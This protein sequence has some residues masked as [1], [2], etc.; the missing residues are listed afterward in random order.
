[1]NKSFQRT[2]VKSR[3]KLLVLASTYPRWYGDYEPGF[4]HE[5][6]KR[7]TKSFDVVVLCPHAPDAREVEIFDGV[8]I[9][10]YRYAPAGLETLVNSGGIV[11]NLKE[12]PWKW[13]LI[14]SFILMQMLWTWRIIKK[15]Q[16]DVIHAHWLLPQGLV[17]ALLK[18]IYKQT[19]PFVVTSH[20]A[21]LFSLK[22]A[23]LRWLKRLVMRKAAALTVVSKVMER[24]LLKEGVDKTRVSVQSMGVDLDQ[25]FVPDKTVKRDEREILFVGRLV[26]KKGLRYLIEAMPSVL[27]EYPMSHLNIVGFGPLESKL[28]ALAKNLGVENKVHFLGSRQHTELPCLYR[29]ASVFVAPFVEAK[30]GDQ[31]GL[32]LVLVEA[33]GCGCP[34]VVSDIAAANDVSDGIRGVVVVPAENSKELAEA[35]IETIREN[36]RQVTKVADSLQVLKNRFNWE[37]VAE[38]YAVKL[39][40]VISYCNK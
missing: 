4:V 12:Y 5:L 1:M 3:R 39:L 26:E 20:G 14:P 10:R 6:S 30:S 28:K 7:L 19:P 9:K 16:P 24:E 22:Q 40:D 8:Y 31:E 15:E 23:P 34:A 32:G 13:L 36:E 33:L 38:E 29:R 21:D 25:R 17:V 2:S 35:I 11:T 18:L 37:H 27:S